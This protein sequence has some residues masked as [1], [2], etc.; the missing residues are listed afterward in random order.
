MAMVTGT[1]RGRAP[2]SLMSPAPMILK[3]GGTG[4]AVL[5][6]QGRAAFTLPD[7][8]FELSEPPDGISIGAVS[9]AT[10]GTAISF[11]ADAAKVRR[12][13][14]GN[15]I[16]EA[17]VER[18]PRQSTEKRLKRRDSRLAFSPPFHSK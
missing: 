15:L 2:L 9:P 12:G 3:A 14:K 13:T 8:I 6:L 16:V 17:F 5:S 4:Q 10:N 1:Y 7:T 18:T 11:R